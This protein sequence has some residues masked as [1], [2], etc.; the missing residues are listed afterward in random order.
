MN[1]KIFKRRIFKFKKY[2]ICI[3][4]FLSACVTFPS[5]KLHF[6]NINCKLSKIFDKQNYFFTTLVTF[7]QLYKLLFPSHK[8]FPHHKTQISSCAFIKPMSKYA[9]F[10][11]HFPQGQGCS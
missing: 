6:K 10:P 7:K 1:K 3:N 11:E 8:E 4:I 2:L 9:A 5:N